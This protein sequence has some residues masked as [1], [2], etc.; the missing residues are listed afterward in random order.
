MSGN[1]K[2]KCLDDLIMV[3]TSS[4]R[5]LGCSMIVVIVGTMSD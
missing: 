1:S 3:D 2:K 5:L 4:G